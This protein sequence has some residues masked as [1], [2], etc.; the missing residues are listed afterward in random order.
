MSAKYLKVETLDIHAGGRDLIFPHH[1]N[2]I[3]QSEALTGK[4]FAKYWMHHGLLSIEG[5]KMSKSLGNFITIKQA[6]SKY[7]ADSLKIFFLGTHYSRPIDFTEDRMSDSAKSLSRFEKFLDRVRSLGAEADARPEAD[8]AIDALRGQFDKSLDDDFNTPEALAALFKMVSIADGYFSDFRKNSG[9]I[10][11]AEGVFKE[12]AGIFG[13]S[14]AKGETG[15]EDGPQIEKKIGDRRK[16]RESGDFKTA[17]KIRGELEA[18]GIILE[19]TKDG[20]IWRRA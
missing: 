13:F 7:K 5:K 14:F 15:P 10:L 2:E 16:A 20:T 6:L 8:Q 12:L 18:M 3:A 1:E 19:D 11:Y 17:D 9:K 4:T